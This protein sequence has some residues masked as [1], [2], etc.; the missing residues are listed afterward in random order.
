MIRRYHYI[1]AVESG[2]QTEVDV[3]ER[4]QHIANVEAK[5]EV[6]RWLKDIGQR[7]DRLTRFDL[8]FVEPHSAKE[9]V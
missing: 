3:H 8:V 5:I 6:E 1:A 4:S 2:D 7:P 9:L